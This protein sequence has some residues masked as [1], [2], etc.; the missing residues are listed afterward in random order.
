MRM[1]H[2]HAC[3]RVFVP[4][5][6]RARGMQPRKFPRTACPRTRFNSSRAWHKPNYLHTQCMIKRMHRTPMLP[7]AMH[8]AKQKGQK[9]KHKKAWRAANMKEDVWKCIHEIENAVPH[10]QPSVR[11]SRPTT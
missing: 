5:R 7:H 10:A 11:P 2:V 4:A 9:I 8:L 3:V 6:G 1:D